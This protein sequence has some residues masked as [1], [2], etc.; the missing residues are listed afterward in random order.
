MGRGSMPLAKFFSCSAWLPTSNDSQ[1]VG[2]LA[3]WWMEG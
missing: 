2:V 1:S 3:I